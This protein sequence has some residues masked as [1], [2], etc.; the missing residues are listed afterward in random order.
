MDWLAGFVDLLKDGDHRHLFDYT[1]SLALSEVLDS[2]TMRSYDCTKHCI[3]S[4]VSGR[5]PLSA[6]KVGM[7]YEMFRPLDEGR[8]EKILE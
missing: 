1:V 2:T 6:G 8:L 7:E 3:L 5:M 4:L